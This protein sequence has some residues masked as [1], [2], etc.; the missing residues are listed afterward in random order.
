V[1]ARVAVVTEQ[2]GSVGKYAI[3]VDFGTASGRA[4]LVDLAG[5]AP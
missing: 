2:G 3:G 1:T 4:I 5:R